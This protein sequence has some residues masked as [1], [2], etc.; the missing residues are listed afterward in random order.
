MRP[1]YETE[2]DRQNEAK[3]GEFLARAWGCQ[4]FKLKP[5]YGVDMAVFVDG[6]MQGVM[7]IKTRHYSSEDLARMGGLILSAH[8]WTSM[9]QWHAV[10]RKAIALV[11][12]LPDGIFAL[13][14]HPDDPLPV[15][16]IKLGGRT[17][18]GDDQDVEP[19]CMIPM[20]YFSL[21]G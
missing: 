20:G 11:L 17:D 1:T 7:E 8:K 16:P 5:Y 2:H 4:F 18:R 15:F 13:T 12:N 19:C 14:V 10:H 6:V 9:A 21:V 3:V